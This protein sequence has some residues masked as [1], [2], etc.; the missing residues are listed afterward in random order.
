MTAPIEVRATA[1][2]LPESDDALVRELAAEYLLW[3]TFVQGSSRVSLHPL[4]LSAQL[5]RQA[6]RTAEWVALAIETVGRIAQSDP[7]EERLYHFHPDVTRLARAS[8]AAGDDAALM[9][10]DLLLDASLQWRVC[11]VNADCPG[12]HNEAHALPRLA[13]RDG[14][15]PGIAP[16]NVLGKLATRLR[17]LAR[18][19]DGSEGT[20]ALIFATAYAE[21]LQVCAII[22]KAIESQ[23]GQAVLAPPTALKMAGGRLRASRVVVDALY[24]FFP[25]EYMEGQTNIG[26]IADAV[27]SGTVRTLSSFSHM[28]AQSKLSMARAHVH[29]RSLPAPLRAAVE[30]GLAH[31]V[32]AGELREEDLLLEREAWVLKRD[33]GRVGDEVFVGAVCEPEEWAK[34]VRE[35]GR[36][37]AGGEPWIAQRFVPQATFATPWG[38]MLVTLGV[39]LLDGRFVGYFARVSPVSHVSHDALCVPVFVEAA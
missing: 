15:P 11:E 5:H 32:D 25:T 2:R 7:E 14:F 33:L 13:R 27:E 8:R 31:T 21:D 17:T 28:F 24:R 38:R 22:K 16:G 20:V 35:I 23:G 26:D 36:L 29:R 6:V 9:R 4:V 37:R 3:D 34:A 39:Y 12:G 18:R 1:C 19:R 10:L 30:S